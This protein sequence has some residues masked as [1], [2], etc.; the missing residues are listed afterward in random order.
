MPDACQLARAAAGFSG[1]PTGWQA[2]AGSCE[3]CSWSQSCTSSLSEG[4]CLPLGWLGSG[5]YELCGDCSWL[6]K[7]NTLILIL[8]NTAHVAII[9]Q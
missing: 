4:Y 6:S 5:A 3:R 1:D 7:L 8:K 9:K 2:G